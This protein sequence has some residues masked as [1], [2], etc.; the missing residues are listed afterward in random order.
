MMIAIEPTFITVAPGVD[1]LHAALVQRRLAPGRAATLKLQRGLH[2]L[3]RPLKLDERDQDT[4]FEGEYG[5][6]ISGG[7]LVADWK[8]VANGTWEADIPAALNTSEIGQRMQLFRGEQRLTLARSAELKY[9]HAEATNVTFAGEDI[10]PDYYD[11]SQVHLVMYESWTASFHRLSSVNASTHTAYLASH[12]N[13]MW[14]NQAAGSRYYVQNAREH[15][16]EVGEFYIDV[17]RRRVM[18]KLAAGDAP[19]SGPPM[20]LAGPSALLQLSGRAGAPLTRVSFAGITFEHTAAESA[21]VLSGADSQSADHLVTAT[22]HVG[23]YTA[24]VTVENCTFRHTGGYAFWAGPGAANC[25]LTR[26]NA[27]DLGAGGVRL[28]GGH[29]ASSS[30]TGHAI[31]DST[32]SDGGHVWQ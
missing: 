19:T 23:A 9:I 12:Y 2:Q 7:I 16:D 21:G 27:Y 18:L 4:A 31:L 20:M 14:A 32:L 11:F 3:T 28:G 1:T 17:P 30:S 6:S 24:H 15:L 10:R 8:H 25:S 5:A 29:T 13:A 26:C 22:V